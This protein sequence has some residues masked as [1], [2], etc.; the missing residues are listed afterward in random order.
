MR[1]TAHIALVA[2]LILTLTMFA[3]PGERLLD[4]VSPEIEGSLPIDE[5]SGIETDSDGVRWTH[6]DSGGENVLYAV[7]AAGALLRQIEIV[8]TVNTDWEELACDEEGNLYIGD[9]G[10]NGNSR[11]DLRIHIIPD[12]ATVTDT[13]TP[14][15]IYYSYEDQTAFPPPAS[16]MHYDLEAFIVYGDYIYLFTKNRTDPMNGYTRLYRLPKTPGTYEAELIDS[17]YLSSIEM[18]AQLTS[19]DITGDILVLMSYRK[20]WIFEGF[21]GADFFSVT[22]TVLTFPGVTQK[23]AI[24]FKQG[25]TDQLW[26]TDEQVT[27]YGIPIGGN[28]YTLDLAGYILNIEE[29]YTQ[30]VK[31]ITAYPNPFND[32]VSIDAD[33]VE[34]Y[35]LS[36]RLVATP[37]RTWQPTSLPSG[38]YLMTTPDREVTKRLIYEK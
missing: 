19:A 34:I 22:P 13:I 17:F 9:V 21:T 31:G 1:S 11:T 8:G 4:S 14:E 18:E 38:I 16:Q 23:E 20:L 29:P 26:L 7:S 3:D 2:S 37:G 30:P 36:G 35:D 28:L 10:N 15:T 33:N 32:T 24:C 27:L 6:D 25:S 12:P 5:S